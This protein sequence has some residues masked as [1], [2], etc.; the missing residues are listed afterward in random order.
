MLPFGWRCFWESLCSHFSKRS[1]F[2]QSLW[3]FPQM[4]HLLFCI[5]CFN[6]RFFHVFPHLIRSALQE[7]AS[8]FAFVLR[9]VKKIH[10]I[11]RSWSLHR[12][13]GVENWNWKVGLKWRWLG[14]TIAIL[15]YYNWNSWGWKAI[16]YDTWDVVSFYHDQIEATCQYQTKLFLHP[17]HD[18]FDQKIDYCTRCTQKSRFHLPKQTPKNGWTHYFS[19]GF[20][21]HR[22]PTREKSPGVPPTPPAPAWPGLPGWSGRPGRREGTVQWW[23]LWGWKQ[24]NKAHHLKVVWKVWGFFLEHLL[25]ILRAVFVGW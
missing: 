12:R 25:N 24:K 10:S 11:A 18:S 23:N 3:W 15:L 7:M 13:N 21:S 4:I 5:T 14:Y 22:P 1:T 6:L 2:V 17:P 16:E 8:T 20:A 9:M 19:T